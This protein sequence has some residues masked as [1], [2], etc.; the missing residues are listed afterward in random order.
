MTTVDT[1]STRSPVQCPQSGPSESSLASCT[2]RASVVDLGHINSCVMS[3]F[4][5]IVVSFRFRRVQSK[6]RDRDVYEED[7]KS[8]KKR[9]RCMRLKLDDE[10]STEDPPAEWMGGRWWWQGAR[11]RRFRLSKGLIICPCKMARWQVRPHRSGSSRAITVGHLDVHQIKR[12]PSGVVQRVGYLQ[13]REEVPALVSPFV[14][15]VCDVARTSRCEDQVG[16]AL[17]P[18]A[19]LKLVPTKL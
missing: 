8:M 11:D 1:V 10:E 13:S 14:L 16:A 9:G 6:K 17:E 18:V 2:A 12:S 5:A 7:K 3:L 4:Q 15:P 19:R